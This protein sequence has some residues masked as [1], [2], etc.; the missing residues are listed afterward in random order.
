MVFEFEN[1]EL[2]SF[3]NRCKGTNGSLLRDRIKFQERWVK[4]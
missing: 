3:H 2:E 4:M 1:F